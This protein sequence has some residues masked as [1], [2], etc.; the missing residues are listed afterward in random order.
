MHIRNAFLAS[1]V[2]AVPFTAANAGETI[3]Y[4]EP[5][6]W[7]QAVD[8]ADYAS[9]SDTVVILDKQS[10]FED[11]ER[12]NYVD[13]ALRMENPEAL[14]QFGT[15]NVQWLPEKGDLVV[16]RVDIVRGGTVI[17]VLEDDALFQV[18]RREAQLEKRTLD[19]VLTA[20]A[21]IP[22]LQV[23]D[24]LRYSITTSSRDGALDGNIQHYDGIQQ[25]PLEIGFGR[26]LLSWPVDE[27][28]SYRTG[29]DFSAVHVPL[30]TRGGY[31]WLDI[32]MPIAKMPDR[33][34][35]APMR[36][37]RGPY[38][39]V[40]SFDDW[41]DVSRLLA[42][43]FQLQG[44]IADGS[45]L[46]TKIAEIAAATT[47]ELER[48]SLALRFVQDEI[49]YLA[50]GL[51]NGN[52]LP[53]SPQE[54][55]DARYGDCKAKSYL[56]AVV[57]GELGIPAETV[58]VHSER[59]DLV[60]DSL[61]MLGVFDHM[62]VKTQIDGRDYWLDGTSRGGR[63]DT[64]DE[65]PAFYFGLPVTDAGSDLEEITQ[66]FQQTPDRILNVTYDLTAGLDMPV[67]YTAEVKGRGSLGALLR[68]Q[69]DETDD[70]ALRKFA[71]DWL[72]NIVGEA[73]IYGVE[74]T[75][76]NEQGV[77]T[78]RASGIMEPQ[79][80]FGRD[81]GKW[82]LALPSTNLKLNADRARAE[83]RDIPV[84]F[85]GPSFYIENFEATLPDEAGEITIRGELE[86]EV[87]AGGIRAARTGSYTGTR[88][89]LTDSLNTIPAVLPSDSLSDARRSVRRYSSADPVIRVSKAKRAWD[90]SDAQL[91]DRM[92]SVIAAFDRIVA[93]QPD[94]GYPLSARAY[95]RTEARD[96]SGAL[97]DYD[98]AIAM[99]ATP[100]LYASRAWAHT[101][102]GNYEAAITDAREAF[103]AR[104]TI[105]DR[106]RLSDLLA[107]TGRTEE[108]L[109]LLD[110]DEFS[111]D[112]RRSIIY[113]RMLVLAEVGRDEE[114]FEWADELVLDQPDESGAW[115]NKC[116]FMAL[117]DH[118]IDQAAEVCDE[119]VDLGDY[120]ASTLDSRA[121]A[122]FRAGNLE[123]AENDLLAALRRNPGMSGSTYLLGII[124]RETGSRREGQ[125]LIRKAQRIWPDVIPYY[126]RFG[127]E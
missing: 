16:H 17:N 109:D 102:A 55:W 43:H 13:V 107:R 106:T 12:R 57:L 52:Y 94:E 35:D 50:N 54:T 81:R 96:F 60:A 64:M 15:V 31:H 92:A 46:A 88:I 117:A 44:Q 69:A 74:V 118:R 19:G 116:W 23:G 89:A 68:P 87:T 21:V 114:G 9:T 97:I 65:V 77:G 67:L 61:P 79:F 123:E 115:N 82:E 108:A 126:R 11:G 36:F 45:E 110:P 91:R 93:E 122:H 38:V 29:P 28:L 127:I 72:E 83:W 113:E 56:L 119:A 63:I 32:S 18:L 62:I 30:E 33:P 104:G 103:D 80:E 7:V 48:A 95:Y 49:G 70:E 76:D 53:Q 10:R 5:A 27:G 4:R 85:G 51:N 75:Y 84:R 90:F 112:D 1:T 66:R 37:R 101:M 59:G 73:D 40:T 58:L 78:M 24:I 86:S 111:G 22:G 14:T 121:F 39:Q 105:G 42:P 2:I 120:S 99:E 125:E 100:G 25:E 41:Q 3:L 8:I 98:A 20:S 71:G 6:D 26:A 34:K 124:R 47:D